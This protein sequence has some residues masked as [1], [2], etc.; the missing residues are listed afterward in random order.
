[1]LAQVFVLH[2]DSQLSG[3]RTKAVALEIKTTTVCVFF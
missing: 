2:F 1:M 3:E